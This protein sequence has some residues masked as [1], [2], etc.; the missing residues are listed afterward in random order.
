MDPRWIPFV[1]GL[2]A[3]CLGAVTCLGFYWLRLRSRNRL[4]EYHDDL[5]NAIRDEQAQLRAEVEGRVAEL[6]DRL[7]FTERHLVAERERPLFPAPIKVPTP[8]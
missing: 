4:T 7:S 8:V 2:I 3:F 1:K 5:I 6:E